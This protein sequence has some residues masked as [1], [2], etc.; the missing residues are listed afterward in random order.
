MSKKYC[1]IQDVK[2]IIPDTFID[3]FEPQILKWIESSSIEI[4]RMTRRSF[5]VSNTE[6]RK[7]DGSGYAKLVIDDIIEI[8]ECKVDDNV[9]DVE[10]RGSIL[11]SKSGFPLGFM[12][13]S[14]TGKFGFS[15]EI[16][17]DINYACAFITA[18]KALFSK[19]GV[20]QVKSEKVGNYSVTYAE[21]Q[22]IKNVMKII[23]S[24]YKHAF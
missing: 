9:R 19:K 17:F 10:H 24:Y 14:V 16:P 8:D 6:T 15:E 13:I 23:S 7:F 4:D 1:T 18:Q 2:N 11:Y 5:D 12:N 22:D 21:G 3:D 20:S